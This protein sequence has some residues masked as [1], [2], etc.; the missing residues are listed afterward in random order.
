MK[1]LS[2]TMQDYL[3]AIATLDRGGEVSTTDI[4]AALKVSPAS[5]TSMIKRLASMKLIQHKAYRGVVLTHAGRKVAM[6]I[7]RHH[8]LIELY[9]AEALGYTWDQVHAEAENLEHHISE[10][11]EDRIAKILGDPK[12]DPHGDPIPTKDGHLPP[13]VH[14]RLCDADV[15]DVLIV[16]RVNDDDAQLLRTL[17]EHGIGLA[18]TVRVV[19]RDETS[20]HITIRVRRTT[21]RLHH[22]SASRIFVERQAVVS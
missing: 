18:T 12:Y 15:D 20:G 6:E 9:L 7:I 11:F 10:D 14:D 22:S 3:K 13:T 16:R 4:A 17:T 2:Q 5:V 8:R 19:E 1:D 21:V